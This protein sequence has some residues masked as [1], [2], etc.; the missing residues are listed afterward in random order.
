MNFTYKKMKIT[1][2]N[3]NEYNEKNNSKFVIKIFDKS[4]KSITIQYDL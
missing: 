4:Q 1:H 3:Y 2:L